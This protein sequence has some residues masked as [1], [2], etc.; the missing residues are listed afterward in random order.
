MNSIKNILT[1]FRN[2]SFTEKNKGT[3][4]ERL[5]RSWLRTD[6]R[7]ANLFEIVWL[8]EEFPSRSDFGGKD[9]GIDLVAKT[10]SGDY[11]AIQCKCYAEDAVIDKPSVDSFLATSSR[12]FSN[13][14]TF[15]QTSTSPRQLS[16]GEKTVTS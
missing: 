3:Q 16:T 12:T 6:A 10:H 14:V 8:W 15:A 11:W 1:H 4:F 5:M 13:E 2:K 7:Y 9:T